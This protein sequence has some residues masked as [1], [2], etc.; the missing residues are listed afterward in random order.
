MPSSPKLKHLYLMK[1]MLDKTDS[2]N[3]MTVPEIIDDLAQYGIK[4]ERRAIY[5]D[6]NVLRVFGIDIKKVKSKTVGYYV[7]SRQFALPELKLLVDAVQSS[8]LITSKMTDQLIQKL[9]ALTSATQAKQLRRQVFVAGRS[10]TPNESVYDNV[11][12]IYAAI[13]DGKKITFQYFDYDL[14]KNRAYRKGGG[15]YQASPLAMLWSDDKYYLI[16]YCDEHKEIRHYRVDRMCG[17]LVL[18]TDTCV[19]EGFD[20]AEYDKRIFGMYSGELVRADLRFEVS[21]I[22]VVLDKFGWDVALKPAERGWF[23][24]TVDVSVSPVFLGWMFQLGKSAVITG[25]AKLIDAMRRH[26]SENMEIYSRR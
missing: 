14:Q 21:L 13:N 9:A 3:P 17:V 23:G 5:D 15:L 25:P 26:L 24:I 20:V 6:L 22:N 2:Q 7:A 1:I 11:D 4:A 12:A 16:A 18:N 8:R 10:R 19:I